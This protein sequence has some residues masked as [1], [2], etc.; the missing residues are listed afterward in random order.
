MKFVKNYTQTQ[1]DLGKLA[2]GEVGAAKPSTLAQYSTSVGK[3]IEYTVLEK[4][5]HL[6][7][8]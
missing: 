5:K 6:K 4:G 1:H 8:M 3:L 7:N 2:D